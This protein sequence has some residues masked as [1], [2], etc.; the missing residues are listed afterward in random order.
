[1]E[2]FAKI[3]PCNLFYLLQ[4]VTFIIHVKYLT[5][6]LFQRADEFLSTPPKTDGGQNEG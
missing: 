1:M 3:V 5:V 2:T 6:C 4:T